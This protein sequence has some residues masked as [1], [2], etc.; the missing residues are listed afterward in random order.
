MQF[1]EVGERG[2]FFYKVPSYR[3]KSVDVSAVVNISAAH[4]VTVFSA[5]STSGCLTGAWRSPIIVALTLQLLRRVPCV[6]EACGTA[7]L[8]GGE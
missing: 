1:Y 8:D 4:D 7:F 5:R 6:S 2:P 3:G